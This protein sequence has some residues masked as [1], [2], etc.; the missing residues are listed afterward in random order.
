M[1]KIREVANNQAKNFGIEIIDVR[2]K[3]TNLPSEN[4]EAIYKRMQTEREKEAREYR[5]QGDG[6]YQKIIAKYCAIR[7]LG[8]V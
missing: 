7:V 2:I 1:N 5:A 6:E 3:K 8:N 4:S